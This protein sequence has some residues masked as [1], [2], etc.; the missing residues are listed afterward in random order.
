VE[1]DVDQ[2]PVAEYQ[3]EHRP[4]QTDVVHVGQQAHIED[5]HH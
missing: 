3:V 1:A 5:G 2:K 4:G